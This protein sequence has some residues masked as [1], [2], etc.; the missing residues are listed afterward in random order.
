[1]LGEFV[2]ADLCVRP[3]LSNNLG[4]HRGPPLQIPVPALPHEYRW[5]GLYRV[6]PARYN[7]L[8]L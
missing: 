8:E 4:G 1:M 5:T 2:G 6:L 3:G 7:Y